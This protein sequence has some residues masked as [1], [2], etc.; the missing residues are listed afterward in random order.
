MYQQ[1]LALSCLVCVVAA[2][3]YSG[4]TSRRQS[5]QSR[6]VQ[7]YS[8]GLRPRNYNVGPRLA[9]G[10]RGYV[11]RRPIAVPRTYQKKGS[12]RRVK[13]GRRNWTPRRTG[14]RKV[15]HRYG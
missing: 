10:K 11:V 14:G 15:G 8:R 1:L 2:H 6:G 5:F 13:A 7:V 3:G 4:V 9:L 12:P